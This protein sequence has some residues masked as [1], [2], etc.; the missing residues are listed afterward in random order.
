MKLSQFKYFLPPELIALRPLEDRDEDRLM[1]V[2]RQTHTILMIEFV[3]LF[4][5][6]FR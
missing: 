5:L 6:L 3:F 1:V 2:D 4:C